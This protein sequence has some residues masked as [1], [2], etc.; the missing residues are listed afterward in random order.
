VTVRALLR[1]VCEAKRDGP[2]PDQIISFP[3]AWALNPAAVDFWY[4]DIL[5]G[6]GK[7]FFVSDTGELAFWGGGISNQA[8]F[9][10]DDQWKLEWL[11][12]S[13][14]SEFRPFVLGPDPNDGEEE[15]AEALRREWKVQLGIDLNDDEYDVELHGF[16]EV[17]DRVCVKLMAKLSEI[18]KKLP[19][20]YEDYLEI[21]Q[22]IR[23]AEDDEEFDFRWSEFYDFCDI[24]RIWM[25]GDFK[26]DDD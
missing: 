20:F 13:E 15:V 23:T 6:T 3:D 14:H 21:L 25:M 2:D 9:W 19:D 4:K 11:R 1:Q 5:R 26:L 7:C 18:E 10:R 8:Y 22:S 17:R 24:A 12:P 16:E